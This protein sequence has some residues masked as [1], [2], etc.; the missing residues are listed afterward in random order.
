MIF[1]H[2]PLDSYKTFWRPAGHMLQ[3]CLATNCDDDT[4][5]YSYM[6]ISIVAQYTYA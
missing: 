6:Y 3:L 5:S 1:E 2:L 4:Q